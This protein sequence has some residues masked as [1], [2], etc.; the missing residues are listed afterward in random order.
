MPWRAIGCRRSD[1][2][3]TE[4]RQSRD[5]SATVACVYMDQCT[6]GQASQD[7]YQ[8]FSSQITFFSDYGK[9]VQRTTDGADN[10]VGLGNA[11][12][13][14]LTTYNACKGAPYFPRLTYDDARPLVA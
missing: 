11:E 7:G 8:E 13:I 9:C 10:S 12:H 14:P 4:E 5:S 3:A 2:C 1:S 6:Y